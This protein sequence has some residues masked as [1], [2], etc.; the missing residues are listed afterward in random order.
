MRPS[1][2][3]K[4]L[5]VLPRKTVYLISPSFPEECAKG[6]RGANT[7]GPG[8]K[9]SP[10]CDRN[11]EEEGICA[12]LVLAARRKINKPP[13]SLSMHHQTLS[14]LLKNYSVDDDPGNRPIHHADALLWLSF[15]SSGLNEDS[16]A[17]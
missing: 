10:L 12:P 11:K 6:H 9:H 13:D 16:S 4:N 5:S 3:P 1:S 8:P 7:A 15:H 2:D 17:I 14:N